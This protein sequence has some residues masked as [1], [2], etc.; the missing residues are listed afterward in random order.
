M[1]SKKEQPLIP[2]K[3]QRLKSTS[4][5]TNYK[6]SNAETQDFDVDTNGANSKPM[7]LALDLGNI[8]DELKQHSQW[9]LWKFE[10]RG[11]KWTKP[12]YQVNGEKAKHNDPTTWSSFDDVTSVY[13]KSGGEFDGIG[14][15]LTKDD[16]FV[17][18][19]LDHCL[20]DSNPN[21]HAIEIVNRFNSFTERSPS[22][23]G[24]HVWVRGNLA[25]GLKNQE[26]EIY[27]TKRYITITGQPW[28]AEN[29]E[30]TIHSRQE[31]L[32]DIYGQ[33]RGNSK[34]STVAPPTR[35]ENKQLPDGLLPEDMVLINQ[36]KGFKN[37]EK[38]KALGNASGEE[39]DWST[40]DQAF[41]NILAF[42]TGKDPEQ[43]DRMV[44]ASARYRPKWDELRGGLTYG[45]MT[46]NKAIADTKE[47]YRGKKT[48]QS[49]G[50]GEKIA[51]TIDGIKEL[52]SV[53][54]EYIA[55]LGNEEFLFDNLIIGNHILVIIAQSGGGK[56]TVL[57][58]HVAPALA[59]AGYKVWY[60]DADSP[61]SDHK[62]MKEVADR[63]GFEFLIPDVNQGTS[64]GN[65]VKSFS[66]MADKGESLAG[67]V[68][69]FDTLKKFIDLMSK[70]SAKEFFVLMRK[71][72]KLGATIILPGHANKH[73]DVDGNLVFEGVGDVKSDADDLIFFES[74]K[75]P[76]GSM[77]V[78]TVVDSSKGSKVRGVFEPISFHISSDR[79]VSVHGKPL[80]LNTMGDTAASKATDDDIITAAVK[81]IKEHGNSIL[82]SQ[83]VEK[84]AT[85]LPKKAGAGRIRKIIK[86][87]AIFK[88]EPLKVGAKFVYTVGDKN[89]HHYELSDFGSTEEV[90]SINTGDDQ[91]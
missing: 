52:F 73:R 2:T 58:F 38:I 79:Q 76:D 28:A 3:N 63:Y 32:D 20:I 91:E 66:E 69:V 16:P 30:R 11:D 8:P 41:C 48:N 84:V 82:Q 35:R 21:E 49:T 40:H 33:Y 13:Q 1:M 26:I 23:D 67:H 4:D 31:E 89:S 45:Q 47:V 83:L 65:M 42:A 72:T 78:T 80:E 51:T 77:D 5:G 74:S 54:S 24:L 15:V 43:M 29:I 70:K 56:T 44:R 85:L 60:I 22:G 71:L 46:I 9:V 61:P 87:H 39:G 57:Y 7:P 10:C 55:G 36:M 86:R 6:P 19:D 50:G 62:K 75:N 27:D 59:N 53:K 12:P 34:P 90:G 88:G 14:F 68:F 25:A 17:C 64:I 37:Y 81:C 18:I